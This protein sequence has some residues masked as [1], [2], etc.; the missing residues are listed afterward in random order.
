MTGM[1]IDTNKK[2]SRISKEIYG[3]FSEH[4]GRC[5]YGGIYV[6]KDSP[7]ENVNGMRSDVVE[8]LK[9]IRVPV[10]RWPGGC[11]ADEYHWK[12]GIGSADTR[13]KIINTNWGGVVEDNSFGTH[14][15]FELCRQLGCETYINGNLGSGTIKEMAEWV[16][17]MTFDGV[18]P[19]AELRKKNGSCAPWKVDF[20]GL[21]NENWG[22]GGNMNP[23]YYANEYRRYQTFIRD[24]NS[25]RHIKKICCGA[26]HDDYEWTKEVLETCFRRV[27]KEQHGFMDG[28]SLHYYVYPEGI[29]TKGSSTDFDQKVWYK[30]LNKAVFMDE[31]ITKH[32]EIMDEYDPDKKIGM[33]VDEWGTWYTCE[34]GINPGFLYQQN[35]MRDALVAGITLNIFNKHSDRVKMANLAQIVNV[36]QAVILTEGDKIV[37]TPTYHV[38][39]IYKYHQDAEL[40]FSDIDIKMIGVENEWQ[41]PNLTESVSITSDGVLHL[42][43]TNLSAE[44]SFDIDAEIIGKKPEK[45]LGEIVTGEIHA[46]NTFDEPECVVVRKYDGVQITE[47][48]IRF[49]IPASSVL[50]LELR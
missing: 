48:G 45:V 47:K 16:E 3:H 38:F 14:E 40:I 33:I 11:F 8:A 43:M 6:G 15:Y 20:F 27:A 7:I 13:K 25:E 36:L 28:L 17:Y 35:T 18:S 44:E 21:G 49:I 1:V 31:L 29:D 10:L 50:H 26:P 41:V 9:Q 32:G 19:M 12:D 39:D 46:K 37:K 30:T 34:P 2:L 5:I 4:L 42:T 22:C 24:Y 23:D